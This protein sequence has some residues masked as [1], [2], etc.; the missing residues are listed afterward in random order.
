MRP[1]SCDG[2]GK[3]CRLGA[4]AAALGLFLL[5]TAGCATRSDYDA[6]YFAEQGDLDA[7]L[8][9]AR[10]AQGEGIDGIFF[11][12]GASECRDYGA[13]VTVL[14][15]KGDFSGAR[16]ACSAYDQQCAVIP[17]NTLCFSY[18]VSELDSAG[19]DAALAETLSAYARETLHYRWL[20]IRD[21]Y[22]GLPIRRPIY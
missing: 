3:G 12:T 5:A 17:G 16:Q 6:V 10:D 8:T 4:L 7:A 15:A 14:V 13:V 9:A 2:P 19:N 1:L 21:D 22:E 20:M 11:G 18:R